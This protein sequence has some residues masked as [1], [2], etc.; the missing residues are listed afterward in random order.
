MND[1]LTGILLEEV[2]E[3]SPYAIWI[4]DQDGILLKANSTLREILNVTNEQIVG[5][6]NVLKDKNLIEQGVMAKV[7]A[8]YKDQV[9]TRFTIKWSGSATR[10]ESFIESPEI[11]ID[12]SM[13]PIQDNKG[14]LKNVVCQWVDIT[15]RKQLIDQLEAGHERLE[16]VLNSVDADIYVADIDTYEILFMNESMKEE[17]GGNCVGDV[18]WK[19]FRGGSEPCS[20]C[21]NDDL[22]DEDGNSTGVLT[23]EGHNPISKKWYANH[24]RAIK[25]IDGRKV[26]LQI[27]FDIT[28]H[29]NAE[30]GLQE[31]NARVSA[32][33]ENSE[34]RIW[35]VDR[36]YRLL[37]GNTTFLRL[38]IENANENVSVGDNILEELSIPKSVKAEWK[39]YYDRCLSGEKFSIE[40]SMYLSEENYVLQYQFNPIVESDGSITGVAVSGRDITEQRKALETMSQSEEKFKQIFDNVGTGIAIY[41]VRDNGKS[42]IFKDI[43][44]AG[45]RRSH[46]VREEILGKNVKEF[47]PMIVDMGLHD[48]FERVWKTG[49]PHTLPTT[50]YQDERISQWVENYVAKLP[51]G[52]IMAVY[53][54][55]TVRKMA[56]DELKKSEAELKK[57]Q[58]VA[59][60]GNWT[61]HIP[62]NSLEWSDEMYRIFGI[63][64]NEF[65]GNLAD[66]MARAI[67]PDDLK[68]VEES[69][70]SVIEK[71]EPIPLE[72]RI[73]HTDG[74]IRN[75]WAEAGELLLDKNGNSEILSGI[76]LDITDRKRIETELRES[77]DKLRLLTQQLISV[78]EE[79]R[80]ILSREL[81]D[82][83]GQALSIIKV[84]LNLLEK[85]IK[86]SDKELTDKFNKVKEALSNAHELFRTISISLRPPVLD[87]IGLVGSIQ[88]LCSQI[89]ER[90]GIQIK[91]EGEKEIKIDDMASII[92]YRVVQESI[93]NVLLHSKS[94]NV[95]VKIERHGNQLHVSIAD[96]GIGF[97]P[98]KEE[99]SAGLGIIGMKERMELIGGS[100]QIESEEGQ[101]SSVIAVY[102]L[103]DKS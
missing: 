22:I 61:W 46:V 101:G 67:H 63:D 65:T 10:D 7:K 69:N 72:Y 78:Q 3:Q 91:Y 88:E 17:F 92:I 20:H 58:E 80:R 94:K 28:D 50:L 82:E 33:V 59:G 23:W 15:E 25:W 90:A 4:S 77:E 83:A 32:I 24:D 100:L 5:K 42:F 43:N 79:E 57:A 62:T 85:D 66:V 55:V 27:S 49:I 2:F 70:I 41:E 12:V 68:A 39:G 11:W 99:K 34:D 48:I 75:V 97:D 74:S 103:E 19:V 81:H 51:S 53:E 14:D 73:V 76:V 6:Y 45:E 56:E 47:F 87:A 37:V 1:Q 86:N 36:N 9:S 98:T 18:C 16:T 13:T 64:K 52:D 8:V 84:Y 95:N 26:K 93:N 30:L 71:N 54:D 60:L 31:Q 89:S 38:M 21:N 102:P 96:D 40:T 35:S 29:K 44:P